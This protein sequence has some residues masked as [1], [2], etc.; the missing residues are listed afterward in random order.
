M[1]D[2]EAFALSAGVAEGGLSIGDA[3]EPLGILDHQAAHLVGGSIKAFFEGGRHAWTCSAAT[4]ASCA[5][6]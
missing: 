6:Y 2:V 5:P 4:T 3:S 1:I